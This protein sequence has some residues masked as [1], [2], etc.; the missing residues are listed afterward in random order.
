MRNGIS[1]DQGNYTPYGSGEVVS[2]VEQEQGQNDWSELARAPDT[3]KSK[4]LLLSTDR[5]YHTSTVWVHVSTARV[6]AS[7]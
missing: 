3:K 2:A 6:I 7:R 4:S 5:N 1:A